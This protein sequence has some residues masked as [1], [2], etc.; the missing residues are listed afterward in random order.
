[1]ITLLGYIGLGLLLSGIILFCVF[2]IFAVLTY[3]KDITLGE[4]WEEQGNY[5]IY[6]ILLWLFS[7]IV[8]GS[9]ITCKEFKN[10]EC[11][12][13]WELKDDTV[14]IKVSGKKVEQVILIHESDK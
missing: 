7:G 5:K 1:M 3:G 10:A 4:A 13:K 14:E 2:C 6:T 11:K 9:M 12:V 8:V